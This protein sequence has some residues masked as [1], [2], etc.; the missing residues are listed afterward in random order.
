M[1]WI[2]TSIRGRAD[3]YTKADLERARDAGVNHLAPSDVKA[4][5]VHALDHYVEN[6]P[7][8]AS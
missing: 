6:P 1:V 2:D 7:A 8:K 4:L 3:R 5:F